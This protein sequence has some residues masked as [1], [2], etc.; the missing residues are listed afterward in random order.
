MLLKNAYKGLSQMLWFDCHKLLLFALRIS[1]W[2]HA[3][4]STVWKQSL[5]LQMCRCFQIRIQSFKCTHQ[6]VYNCRVRR[7][8]MLRAWHSHAPSHGACSTVA[9]KSRLR[10]QEIWQVH[11]KYYMRMI[12][13]ISNWLE[14]ECQQEQNMWY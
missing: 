9:E 13:I 11:A 10:C 3:D 7:R 14:V 6:S 2:W 1:I 5:G 8:G 4:H 12:H